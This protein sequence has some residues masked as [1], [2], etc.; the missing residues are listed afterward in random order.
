MQRAEA[1]ARFEAARQALKSHSLLAHG[2][3]VEL[4]GHS[5]AMLAA[6]DAAGRFSA[7]AQQLKQLTSEGACRARQLFKHAAAFIIATQAAKRFVAAFEAL[8]AVLPAGNSE[9]ASSS[10]PR[11]A[12]PADV[13][14]MQW[15]KAASKSSK[16]LSAGAKVLT[17][18]ASTAG[19]RLL[20]RSSKLSKSAQK[21]ILQGAR[22]LSKGAAKR[23]S[24]L[25]HRDS[26]RQTGSSSPRQTAL[27]AAVE[28]ATEAEA[29]AD[30]VLAAQ[31]LQSLGLAAAVDAAGSIQGKVAAA[32]AAADS[33][34]GIKA[35]C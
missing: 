32:E 26:S 33:G 15:S 19:R 7:A 11:A 34:D 20:K 5:A 1:A 14:R 12:S 28:S 22:L 6:L 27:R 10:I 18:S 24:K 31:D 29:A 4:Y 17:Q 30:A 21:K 2:R 3:A 8:K 16:Q 13:L 35:V 25:Q 9:G 23:L